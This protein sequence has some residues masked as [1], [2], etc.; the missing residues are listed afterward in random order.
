MCAG[1]SDDWMIY[2]SKLYEKWMFKQEEYDHT[3]CL[4]HV[5]ICACE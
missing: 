1:M 4:C 3:L 5:H 2:S